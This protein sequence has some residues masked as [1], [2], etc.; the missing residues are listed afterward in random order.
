MCSWCAVLVNFPISF[1][2]TH[3]RTQ[4]II[5]SIHENQKGFV[6]TQQNENDPHNV[7]KM[8]EMVLDFYQIILF[9]VWISSTYAVGILFAR[10]NHFLIHNNYQLDLGMYAGHLSLS[11]VLCRSSLTSTFVCNFIVWNSGLSKYENSKRNNFMDHTTEL[12]CT[13]KSK[14]NLFLLFSTL[15]QMQAHY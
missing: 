12:R 14:T 9:A 10:T 2:H 7:C 11:L 6:D 13:M 1:A 4:K 5:E 8:I 3:A 15:W